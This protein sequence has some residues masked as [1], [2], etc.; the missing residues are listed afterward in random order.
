MSLNSAYY[1]IKFGTSNGTTLLSLVNGHKPGRYVSEM[2]LIYTMRSGAHS[3]EP[4][5]VGVL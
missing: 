4:T 1:T 2:I 5:E 3:N